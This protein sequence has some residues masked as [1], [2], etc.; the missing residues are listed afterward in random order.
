MEMSRQA[1]LNTMQR[2]IGNIP[3]GRKSIRLV[4]DRDQKHILGFNLMG[5][6]IVRKF[7]S[8]GSRKDF[9]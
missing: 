1:L 9:D 8:N 2:C 7:A 5:F 6:A 3:M 4:Y